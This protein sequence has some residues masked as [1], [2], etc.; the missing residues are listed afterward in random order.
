MLNEFI[1]PFFINNYLLDFIIYIFNNLISIKHINIEQFQFNWDWDFYVI[2]NNSGKLEIESTTNVI[3]FSLVNFLN[4]NILTANLPFLHSIKEGN[5]SARLTNIEKN[6]IFLTPIQKEILIGCILGNA[7]LELNS[8]THN[9][10]L[11][12]YQTFPEHAS[13]IKYLYSIFYYLTGSKGPSINI[14]K[15]DPRT[16]KIYSSMAFKTLSLPCLNFYYDLF[17]D[18]ILGKIIPS[19]IEDYLTPRSLA[20]E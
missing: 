4:Y 14:R 13:Y 2:I 3:N 9:S 20:F 5:R 7:C 1:T 12:F 8:P 18:P 10:R 6:L 17:Y 11:R 15:P 19:N 16:N